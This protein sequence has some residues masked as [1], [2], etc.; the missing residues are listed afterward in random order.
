MATVYEKFAAEASS[1][2]AVRSLSR[3]VLT[4]EHIIGENRRL[5][6][7]VNYSDSDSNAGF[8]LADGWRL[9]KYHR[10]ENVVPAHDAVIFEVTK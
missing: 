10:G 8:E 6:I 9:V 4:T 2:R 1:T 7:A 3:S 5:I